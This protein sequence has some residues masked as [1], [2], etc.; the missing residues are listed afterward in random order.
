[1]ADFETPQSRNEAILQNMLGANNELLPPQSRIETLLTE[2][3][4]KI[5]SDSS[6]SASDNTLVKGALTNLML[7]WSD[8]AVGI[9]HIPSIKAGDT[10]ACAIVYKYG[11]LFGAVLLMSFHPNLPRPVYCRYFGGN[12][13]TP[14]WL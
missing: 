6:G 9:T 12:W 5:S 8:Y 14:L 4:G 2:L 1:M 10:V 13:Q 3:L 11:A 7:N